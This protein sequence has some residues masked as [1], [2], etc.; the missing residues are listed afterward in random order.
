MHFSLFCSVTTH[1]YVYLFI[2]FC[3]GRTRPCFVAGSKVDKRSAPTPLNQEMLSKTTDQLSPNTHTSIHQQ[4][5]L[6]YDFS[7]LFFLL[8]TTIQKERH[9][10]RMEGHLG[11]PEAHLTSITGWCMQSSVVAYSGRATGD[12]ENRAHRDTTT[13]HTHLTLM[14]SPM[15]MARATYFTHLALSS[16]LI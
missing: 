8:S 11:K 14:Q 2:S 1:Q 3:S 15:A 16:H 7:A 5:A 9:R 4:T 6:N 10:N 12:A 13:P